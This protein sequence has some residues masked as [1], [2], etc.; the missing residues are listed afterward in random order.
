MS[1]F[2][3]LGSKIR[4]QISMLTLIFPFQNDTGADTYDF[5]SIYWQTD[6][7]ER[8]Q[9]RINSSTG[10]NNHFTNQSEHDRY[11]SRTPVNQFLMPGTP[12]EARWASADSSGNPK[13]VSSFANDPPAVR[14]T[15][16]SAAAMQPLNLEVDPNAWELKD[17]DLQRLL[18][19]ACEY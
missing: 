7:T 4:L 13:I 5:D 15:L 8:P 12:A 2:K 6:A 9:I 14:G 16:G 18:G 3:I 11:D 1:K 19:G 17:H 10:T